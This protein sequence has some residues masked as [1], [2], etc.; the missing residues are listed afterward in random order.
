MKEA[1][2]TPWEQVCVDLVGPWTTIINGHLIQI[3]VLSVV[4]PDTDL[5]ELIHV[6]TKEAQCI[7]MDFENNWLEMDPIPLFCIHGNRAEFNRIAI[8]KML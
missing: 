3:N 8:Q 4:D 2:S 7:A 1:V 5:S 6:R